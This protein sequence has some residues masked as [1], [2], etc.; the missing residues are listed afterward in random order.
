[1]ELKPLPAELRSSR[2]DT[3]CKALF[4]GET[5]RDEA[6]KE[7]E[8]ASKHTDSRHGSRPNSAYSRVVDGSLYGTRDLQ[9]SKAAR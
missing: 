8:R 5:K 4:G 2:E 7:L 6:E 9:K 3:T 1:M